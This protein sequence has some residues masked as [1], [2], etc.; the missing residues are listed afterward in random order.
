[1]VKN[2]FAFCIGGF[3]SHTGYQKLQ[4]HWLLFLS[5]VL[6]SGMLVLHPGVYDISV[7]SWEETG[8]V[9]DV[10]PIKDDALSLQSFQDV[11]VS[12][13]SANKEEGDITLPMDSIFP[14]SWTDLMDSATHSIL[15]ILAYA[16]TSNSDAFITT[17]DTTGEKTT[18][19]NLSIASVKFHIDVKPGSQV[20][21]DWG[22]GQSNT[23]NASQG[24]SHNYQ[25]S[26]PDVSKTNTISITGDLE[27]FYF[28]YVES[29]KTHDSP[30]LLMSLDQWGDAKWTDMTNMFRGATNMQYN[31]TDVPDL[32]SGPDVDYMFRYVNSFNGDLSD[33]DVSEMTDLGYMFADTPSFNSDI[34]GWDVSKVTSMAYMFANSPSFNADISGWDVSSV[35]YMYYMFGSASSFNAD[36]S[37][38]DVSSVEYMY[39]MFGAASSFNADI[40]GWDVS[41]MYSVSLMSEMF[42]DASSF[43]QNLGPWFIVLEDTVVGHDKTQVT[44]ISSQVTSLSSFVEFDAN[45]DNYDITGADA[46]YFTITDGHLVLNSPSDYNSKSQYDIT[47]TA[48]N[49]VVDKLYLDVAPSISVTI[50]VKQPSETTVTSIARHNPLTPTTD[51]STLQF[52]VLFSDDVTNVNSEDFELSSS[53]PTN[54]IPHTYTS[55]PS[56]FIPYD[57]VKT[58]TITVSDSDTVSAVSVSVDITHAWIGDLLVELISPDNQVVTLHNYAGDS[59]D[60]IVKTYILEYDDDVSINGDWQLRMYDNYNADSGTLNNWSIAFGDDSAFNSITSVTGSGNLYYV[61]VASSQAG[62]YNLDIAEDNDIVDASS[63]SLASRTPT[64]GDQS[65]TVTATDVTTTT[66]TTPPALTLVGSPTVTMGVGTT[67]TED[68][69]TCIDNNDG[70]ISS[71]IGMTGSVNT[72]TAGTYVITYTCTDAANNPATPITRTVSVVDSPPTVTSI[73]R[74]SPAEQNTSNSTLQFSVLFSEAVTGV[75]QDDFELSSDSPTDATPQTF[76]YSSEPSLFVPYGVTKT[77]TITVSDSATVTSVSVSVDITHTYIGDLKVELVAPDNT[78]HT[79]HNHIGGSDDDIVKTYTLE[80]DD[81]VSINGDWQLRLYDNYDADEGT[82]NSW[83]ITFGDDSTPNPITAVTGSGTLYYVTVASPQTG[84]YNLDIAEDNDIVDASSNSLASRT[85]TGGDQSYTVTATDVTTTTDTTPPALTLVG[86]PT[87]TMGVGT[88]YTEDGATCIDNN[89]GDISSQIGMTGSV[90]TGTA[91]TYVITYTCTDAANNPATPITRT[92]SVVDSPP[93][94]TTITRHSPAEQNTSNSTLQFS[95]LFS[96]AV[97][98]VGQ[99][100]FELSSDSPTDATPQTFTY[101][102]EPSLFVP[103]GVT[104]T[105]TITVSDSATVTSVSVS[106]DITHTYIGDLKVELVA[107]DNTV[108]ILHN[109]IG[110]SDDDIVKTYTLEYDDD[111]SINGDWQLRLYDNYDADEGTLNSWSITF[112]DGSTPNPITAVTGSDNQYYVTV[113]S[114]QAGTYNLDIAEDNDIVDSSNNSLSSRTPTGDDQ[115]YTVTV[116]ADATPPALTLVGSPTVTMGVGTTYTEDGATCIDNNDGDISSQIGMTGSVN[117]GTAGTYVITYTCTDAANNP[118][119]PITRTVS[120]VDSPPTVTTITRHSPAEQN[121]S[122]S[123]LQFSVLFSEAVTG[124]GQDDFEL[125]SDSPTDATPQTFTYSSE[126]SLFVPYGVTKTDTIT[127]S[128]SAT[129]TSVSVSVDITHTYIGDLKVELVAPDNTVRILHN[130]IGGSDDDI[131]KTYTPDFGSVSINGDWQLRL[132]D[133]YDADEGTLNSWSITF[134]DGSTPNPIT[135]VTGS[136][137]Q[138]YV[139]VASS[140]AGTYNLDIAE[141]NDIVD[142]SNNS[143]SSRTPTGDDQSYT[144]TA[145]S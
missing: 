113:A 16:Q 50:T 97:T 18:T 3:S 67:Y 104:K 30:Q 26:Q 76:T 105:D 109:H 93:T 119:T 20:T 94:V 138:Y 135:A 75:S 33:W 99:D 48:N 57:T 17:W 24:V 62:T 52:K 41:S 5:V 107:P 101:S 23:Y 63:N 86:S 122:N 2:I 130:H 95:V 143:L 136:D 15:P 40:S 108:R 145:T 127:V 35:E 128:D 87:V 38:W 91:G 27:R 7:S 144:V 102:S 4:L 1:M 32:S 125:S 68:G 54:T 85:P 36:I 129:V 124:V 47:I 13:T 51:S 84:T 70:D 8:D 49:A 80:Y 92:V 126:P 34:S 59:A 14:A 132:Y 103:Y 121:T 22:N 123:T 110:G 25:N 11:I 83:S 96:E 115:S 28:Y 31:V 137:N 43:D 112:G 55:T 140:Q 106:V 131:V 53:S 65:Y 90:N 58:D 66:D 142:S 88:T 44:P 10:L 78:A 60:D 74:H 89:D 79:L 69:A 37:G 100:D 73:T 141:D 117:T 12:A 6:V 71:Q 98:G 39:N 139:T 134:G 77:D 29:F 56:L 21:V 9:F 72:G 45:T 19:P 82:L 120:V 118:A 114:S 116:S 42:Y 61:T 111:V 64:G 81:D 46:N 133:N